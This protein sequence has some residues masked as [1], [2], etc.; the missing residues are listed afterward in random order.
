M[1]E[2]VME[3]SGDLGEGGEGSGDVSSSQGL[4]VRVQTPPFEII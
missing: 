4:E 3:Y 1:F 2:R